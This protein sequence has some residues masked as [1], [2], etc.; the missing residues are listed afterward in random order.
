MNK[1]FYII[2]ENIKKSFKKDNIDIQISADIDMNS[3]YAIYCGLIV[4]EAITNSFKYAFDGLDNKKIEIVLKKKGDKYHLKVKDNGK[5]FMVKS[6]GG[7]GIDIIDTLAT[8][9]LD[10]TLEIKKDNGVEI[11]IIWEEK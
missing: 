2:T 3:E 6:K 5:G 9:Q 4:N 7:L 11:N 10:G 8:L 1:Y